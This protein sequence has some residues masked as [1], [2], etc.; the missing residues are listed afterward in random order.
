MAAFVNVVFLVGNGFDLAAGL[1]TSAKDFIEEFVDRHCQ[2]AKE[3]CS[4]SERLAQTMTKEGLENWSDYEKSIGMYAK[5]VASYDFSKIET[6]SPS[7]ELIAAKEAVDSALSEMI[8]RES[9]RITKD[10]IE[11]NVK[12]CMGSVSKWL[13]AFGT[14]HR[15]EIFR[16]FSHPLRFRYSFISFNYTSLFDKFYYASKEYFQSW[17]AEFYPGSFPSASHSLG[18][19]CHAHGTIEDVPICGVNDPDQIADEK[20]K[21]NEGVVS[22]IVKPNIQ[23]MFARDD[24][25]LAMSIIGKAQIVCVFGMSLGSTDKRWW[26]RIV[27]WLR[28]NGNRYLIIFKRGVSAQKITPAE[29]WRTVNEAK[30]TLLCSA[31]IEDSN[32]RDSVSKRIFVA[33]SSEVFV[34]EG[35][36]EAS[37]TINE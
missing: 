29:Y 26:Q 35:Q 10:Y 8:E 28:G 6:S 1:N 14:E 11:R 34:L 7:E 12:S 37:K 33:N 13:G 16:S 27:E 5:S 17:L 9:E 36:I 4:P 3:P 22:A 25:S 19:L 32:L 30:E 31:E 18:G 23:R 24:D 2:K 21:V 15:D 20:L